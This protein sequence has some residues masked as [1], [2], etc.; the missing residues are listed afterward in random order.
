MKKTFMNYRWRIISLVALLTLIV[1]LLPNFFANRD[2]YALDRNTFPL[3]KQADEPW[4]GKYIPGAG[5]MRDYGCAVTSSAMVLAYYGS[6]FTPETLLNELIA[7]KGFDNGK[8]KWQS[9]VDA[10]NGSLSSCKRVTYS[11]LADMSVINSLIDAGNPVILDVR[12]KLKSGGYSMHFVV[13]TGRSGDI[14]Y[15]NDP[16]LGRTT[17]DKYYHWEGGAA[18]A[19]YG[20]VIYYPGTSRG[21]QPA[22]QPKPVPSIPSIPSPSGKYSLS[23][24]NN[25]NLIGDVVLRQS[26]DAIDLDWGGNGPGASCGSD[27]FSCLIEG[28]EYFEG[29]YYSFGYRVDD[30]IQIFV[31]NEAIL[32]RWSPQVAT[33]SVVKYISQGKHKITV[34][35]AEMTGEGFIQI[36]IF[37]TSAPV[38][39][40][41]PAPTTAP[42]PTVAPA[43]TVSP[44]ITPPTAKQRSM[45]PQEERNAIIRSYELAF[46]SAGEATEQV[47]AEWQQNPSWR[48]VDDL[49]AA[50]NQYIASHTIS[51]YSEETVRKEFISLFER[52]CG[53]SPDEQ[54][55]CWNTLQVRLGRLTM[56]DIEQRI[57]D[58]LPSV[59]ATPSV[60][61]TPVPTT[62]PAGLTNEQRREMI[63]SSY[64]KTMYRKASE[65][66]VSAWL[67]DLWWNSEQQLVD[68]HLKWI[69]EHTVP[70]FD[71]TA[72]RQAIIDAFVANLGYQPTDFDLSYNVTACKIGY[73]TIDKIIVILQS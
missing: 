45:T 70:G 6:Q 73:L 58:G 39:T 52:L 5:Y 8:I 49:V 38:P 53:F 48:T 28:D 50:H 9:V 29:G 24:Y 57:I 19:I 3:F 37:K 47:I 31:D 36:S 71:E 17:L 54:A 4:G 13:C 16:I 2:V 60:T 21:N 69:E 51:G 72:T 25:D 7:R 22:P 10:S 20:Y 30:K 65:G 32:D 64:E 42:V 68:C 55:I 40:A 23:F 66:E 46:Y 56:N 11:G 41:A 14:Y 34:K 59:P 12:A 18:R 44:T 43:P 33:G 15:I 27:Y 61:P 26:T 63:N 67:S 35:Y 62:D 1:G